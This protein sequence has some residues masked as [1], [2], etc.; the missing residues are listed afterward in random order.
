MDQ[1]TFHLYGVSH[2]V[3]LFVI[4][5]GGIFMVAFMRSR[6]SDKVKARVRHSFGLLL[7]FLVFMDPF[8]T[9][10]R[11]GNTETG[12]SLFWSTALPL[13]L[14]DVVSI[15]AAIALFTQKYQFVE[16]AYFWGLAGTVQGLLTPTLGYDWDTIEYYSF[17]LQHGGIP[18]AAVTLVW[19]LGIVPRKGAFKRIVLWSWCYMAMVMGINALIDQNYG[20]LSSKPDVPTMLDFMGDYPYYLITLQVIAFSLYFV[21]LKIAPSKYDNIS[22]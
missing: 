3:A 19:G 10:M 7:I 15:V 17:F 16:V 8:L 2:F 18:I 21:L 13:Y 14:C 11:W 4:A 22:D 9:F 20:F 12:W 6:I 5:M 1:H